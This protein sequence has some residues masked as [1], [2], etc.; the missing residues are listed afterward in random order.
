MSFTRTKWKTRKY[1]VDVC[2]I[3]V[4][5]AKVKLTD[6]KDGS[7]IERKLTLTIGETIETI[8]RDNICEYK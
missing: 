1:L 2:F 4:L 3:D 7:I 5:Y 6:R 8:I